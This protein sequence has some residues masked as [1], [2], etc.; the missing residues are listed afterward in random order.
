[1]T[2]ESLAR[3]RRVSKR[4]APKG[5]L[6]VSCQ[7]GSWGLGGNMAVSVLDVSDAGIRL[8]LSAPLERNQE[9]SVCLSVPGK[10]RPLKALARV[11]WSVETA[12]GTYCV[13][14]AFQRRLAHT[15]FLNLVSGTLA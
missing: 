11:V 5:G 12:E 10:G 3:N 13:G 1:M 2:Q 15:D 8:I 9:L 4:K 14:A 7:K 6:H